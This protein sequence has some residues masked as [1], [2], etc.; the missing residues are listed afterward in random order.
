[1]NIRKNK[2]G[3]TFAELIVILAISG[4]LLGGIIMSFQNFTSFETWLVN[5]SILQKNTAGEVILLE[6]VIDEEQIIIS[7]SDLSYTTEKFLS[8]EENLPIFH[9][10]SSIKEDGDGAQ[11]TLLDTQGYLSIHSGI[12]FSGMVEVGTDLFVVDPGNHVI[13]K[14]DTLLGTEVVYAGTFGTAGGDNNADS[15]SATF[16]NPTGITYYNDDDNGKLYVSDTGN[17][18]IRTI[19]IATDSANRTVATFAGNIGIPGNTVG[20]KDL[21]FFNNPTGITVNPN[22]GDLYVSDTGNHL[23]KKISSGRVHILLGTAEPNNSENNAQ[24]SNFTSFAINTPTNIVYDENMSHL[25]INDFLNKR[26][27]RL[28]EGLEVE[29]ITNENIYYGGVRIHLDDTGRVFLDYQELLS[30]EIFSMDVLDLTLSSLLLPSD[31][32]GY[33]GTLFL[34]Q[35]FI[36]DGNNFVV[37]GLDESN[38]SWTLLKIQDMNPKNAIVW[39]GTGGIFQPMKLWHETAHIFNSY[40]D[41][42][43]ESLLV[44]MKKRVNP[45]GYN[46][47]MA[48]LLLK[49]KTFMP[50]KEDDI[51]ISYSIILGK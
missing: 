39:H 26:I 15:L 34:N 44:E 41:F 13:R 24:V 36:K 32:E 30:G 28:S 40:K 10:V 4:F 47:N 21:S 11:L 35:D 45:S 20:D 50:I 5:F 31:I 3:F 19:T 8:R 12:F 42:I 9:Y 51:E 23:I 22:S 29:K 14:I 1:V 46:V 25:Y 7:T 6:K 2:L 49:F 18:S 38:N 43:G 16:R 33:D 27:L 37:L 48:E 17:H